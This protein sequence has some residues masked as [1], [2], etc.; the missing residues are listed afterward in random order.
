MPQLQLVTLLDLPLRRYRCG[1]I[2]NDTVSMYNIHVPLHLQSKSRLPDVGASEKTGADRR[3]ERKAKKKRKQLRMA[4]RR[5]REKLIAKLRPGLGNKYSKLRVARR[6][7]EGHI[8]VDKSLR[9]SSKFFAQL[10]RE[11]QEEV[12]RG[13]RERKGKN[14]RTMAGLQYK[15]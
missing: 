8:D 5:Q 2:D 3:R 11:V 13:G 7:K 9:S 10:Q 14:S 4:E 12:K 1:T 6:L 15:L